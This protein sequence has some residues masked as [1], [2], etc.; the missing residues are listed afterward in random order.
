[1]DFLKLH[2]AEILILIFLIITFSISVIEKFADWK[3]TVSYITDTFKNTIINPITKP[4]LVLLVFFEVLTSYFLIT[5]FYQLL[6]SEEKENALL[7]CVFSSLTIL[8]MLLGQRIAK[9]YPGATS[10]GVYFLIS[11]FGVFMLN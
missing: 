1:M 11:V 6:I 2:L 5:G 4:L 7:G 3:G 8:C 10:L 9:D